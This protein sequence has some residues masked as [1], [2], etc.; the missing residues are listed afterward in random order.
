MA[1]L[2]KQ[3]KR[4]KKLQARSKKEAL[5]DQQIDQKIAK[6]RAFAQRKIAWMEEHGTT[7]LPKDFK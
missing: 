5:L 3:Q 2:T 1:K 6:E 4:K 7:Q